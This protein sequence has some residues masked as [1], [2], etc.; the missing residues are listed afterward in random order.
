[1]PNA[2]G[3]FPNAENDGVILHIKL[4]R[5]DFVIIMTPEPWIAKIKPAAKPARIIVQH[6]L[7]AI[8]LA[9]QLRPR[10]FH[11]RGAKSCA[12]RVGDC[13]PPQP[14]R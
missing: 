12:P 14:R 7:P 6:D 8:H 1:M 3:S 5:H 2:V 11:L 13:D 10:D 4:H 9:A